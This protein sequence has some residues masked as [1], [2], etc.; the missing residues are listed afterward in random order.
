MDQLRDLATTADM[1]RE[2]FPVLGCRKMP[3]MHRMPAQRRKKTAL[4]TAR[5]HNGERRGK[6]LTVAAATL[7]FVVFVLVVLDRVFPLPLPG[8]GGGGTVVLARD[9]SP[10]RAF[11]DTDGVWRY[12]VTLDQVSPLYVDALLTYE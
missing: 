6:R 2:Q 10:L 5:G 11:A 7:L 4:L 1:P 9:N 12:P 3:T 8:E